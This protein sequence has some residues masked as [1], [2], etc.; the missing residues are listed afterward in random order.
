MTTSRR[1]FLGV[2]AVFVSAPFVAMRAAGQTLSGEPR[3]SCN[4]TSPGPCRTCGKLIEP[5][6]WG[7]GTHDD[8]QA[9]Q[10]LLDGRVVWDVYEGRHRSRPLDGSHVIILR[11]HHR[12]SAPLTVPNRVTVQFD[13]PSY[14]A[15][16]VPSPRGTD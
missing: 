14:A 1:S 12:I 7:D 6:L 16:T 15:M 10:A 9:L 4:H 13:T 5:V 2:V 8:R 11:R 3:S